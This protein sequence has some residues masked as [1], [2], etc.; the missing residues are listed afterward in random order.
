VSSHEDVV[1]DWL[2]RLGSGRSTVA[3]QALA[4]EAAV[5]LSGWSAGRG[6][7]GTRWDKDWAAAVPEADSFAGSIAEL[8]VAESKVF[9]PRV[10]EPAV[11][12]VVD[13]SEGPEES[14]DSEEPEPLVVLSVGPADPSEVVWARNHRML[15]TRV[16]GVVSTPGHWSMNAGSSS[17]W[18]EALVARLLEFS[19][20]WL[21]IDCAGWS[22]GQRHWLRTK[23]A[24]GSSVFKPT[25]RFEACHISDR[26]FAR[27]VAQKR[28]QVQRGKMSKFDPDRVAAPVNAVAVLVPPVLPSRRGAGSPHPE[29]VAFAEEIRS[30]HGDWVEIE[31]SD[32]VRSFAGN[33]AQK[34]GGLGR[35][36]RPWGSF[37]A[38]VK[39]GRLYARALVPTV[40]VTG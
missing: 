31:V 24:G 2:A 12:S 40:S 19:G 29:D 25:G 22:F 5:W 7:P 16:A 6:N 13:G 28:R 14:G 9:A 18:D 4:D 23:I 38:T 8:K 34:I 36:Y 26:V 10:A 15:V 27:A 1:R 30:Y 11:A 3:E 35:A 37:E 17:P 21:E 32:R 33:F 20:S 39:G